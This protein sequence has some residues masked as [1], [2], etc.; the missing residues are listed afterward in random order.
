MLTPDE[1]ARYDRQLGIPG[2][3][4]DAQERLKRSR[5][6]VA[7]AGG[8]GSPVILY[9]AAAGVGELI[10]CDSDVIE[11]SNLNRQIIHRSDRLGSEKASS[12]ASSAMAINPLVS[13]RAVHAMITSKNAG[14]LIDGVDLVIDCLDNFETRHLLNRAIVEKGIPM[15]HG[16]VAG[17]AGQ[18]MFIDTPETACLACV[19]PRA[20]KERFSITGPTA[21]IIG[22][23]QALEALRYCTGIGPSLKGKILF[24]DGFAMSCETIGVEPNQRCSVCRH[25]RK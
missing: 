23:I 11:P 16:G 4:Q 18:V 15:I 19:F 12:A 9:L 2:W 21:G 25:V 13:V 1:L 10:V 3:G 17:F 24:W 5:V 20:K 6:F 14:R 8:L 7:G 22:S